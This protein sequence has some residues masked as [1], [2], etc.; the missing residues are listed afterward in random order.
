MLYKNHSTPLE[1]NLLVVK[2]DSIGDYLLFRNFLQS[3]KKSQRYKDYKITLCGNNW[4]KEI[5]EQFDKSWV[6]EFVWVDYNQLSDYN[7]SI[8]ISKILYKKAFDVAISPTYSRCPYTDELMLQ[9]GAKLKFGQKGN[10]VNINSV[11]K[12]KNDKRFTKLYELANGLNFEFES[13]LDFFSQIINESI[14]FK[15]PFLEITKKPTASIIIAPGAKAEFRRWSPE[16]FFQLAVYLKQHINNAEFIIC[17]A[18]SE[19]KLAEDIIQCGNQISFINLTGKLS[20]LQ[21]T[22]YMAKASLLLCND[23]GPYHLAAVL[24]IPVICIS[25]GNH[26]GRFCPYPK[27]YNKKHLEIFPPQLDTPNLKTEDIF[28]LQTLGSDLNINSIEV[29]HVILHIQ[30]SNFLHEI[31]SFTST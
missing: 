12:K 1:K 3:L 9:S 8:S 26:Y 31:N 4:W 2:L 22:E 7:Y 29:E 5:S 30:E 18:A 25:N 28:K 11:L 13:N 17:G 19:V 23:S 14:R 27:T 6:S 21:L 10:T 15:Q 24:N 20:M 16:N